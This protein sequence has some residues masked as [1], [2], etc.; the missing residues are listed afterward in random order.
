[1]KPNANIFRNLFATDKSQSGK[2]MAVVALHSASTGLSAL[3]TQIDV[4]ANNLANANTNGFK[5][6]RVNFEAIQKSA[7]TPDFSP[8]NDLGLDV[9]ARQCLGLEV[10]RMSA[11]LERALPAAAQ[12][13]CG[14]EAGM[15]P[16]DAGL[17][18]AVAAA[19]AAALSSAGCRA[20]ASSPRD[21]G[22]PSQPGPA[23]NYA[24]DFKVEC[25]AGAPSERVSETWVFSKSPGAGSRP[26][27][28]SQ[29]L[30]AGA[31]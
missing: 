19:N 9:C 18:G 15:G 26:M 10:N 6:S 24:V 12:R 2:A 5:S 23:G 14:C 28:V 29:W 22:N 13:A 3:S 11:S 8:W 1:M 21:F 4:I 20:S 25:A 30:A 17:P 16:D 31:R 27:P 7:L